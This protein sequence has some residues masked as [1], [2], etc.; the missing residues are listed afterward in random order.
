MGSTSTSGLRNPVTTLYQEVVNEQ[1]S[2]T[3]AL[4]WYLVGALTVAAICWIR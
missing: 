4:F 3:D 2:W 1:A